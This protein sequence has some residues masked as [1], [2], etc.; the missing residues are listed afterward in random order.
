M[1][2]RLDLVARETGGNLSGSQGVQP[3]L[4]SVVLSSQLENLTRWQSVRESGQICS[5]S[6]RWG[7][8]NLK[9][10]IMDDFQIFLQHC[11]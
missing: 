2:S 3:T 6:S 7:A 1:L 4:R 11:L 9:N 8:E 5:S 10:R